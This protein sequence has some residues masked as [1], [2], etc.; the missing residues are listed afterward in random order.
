MIESKGGKIKE[1]VMGDMDNKKRQQQIGMICAVSCAVIWGIL[2]VYWKS[3]ESINSFMIM[4]YRLLLAFIVVLVVCL[5][6]YKPEGILKPLKN[7]KVIPMFF[8]AGFIIS[9]NWST[10]IWA[11]NAGHIIQTSIGYYIEPLF[12]AILGLIIFHEKLNKYKTIAI[13]LAAIGVCIMI[14]SYG[15][16]PTIAL[17]L[18]VSFA[19]YAALKKKLQAPALLALLYETG[20]MLPIVIPC[21]IFMEVTGRGV[22]GT[23]DVNQ[24]ILLSFSGILTAI[25]LSLFGLAANRVSI[26]TLGLTE[27]LS[28][29]LNL[30]IGIFIYSEPF[31]MIQL[32]GFIVIWIGLAVFTIGEVKG[33]SSGGEGVERL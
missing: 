20:L 12:V 8:F 32:A 5:I 11:V 26:I 28:P 30:A 6:K 1:S 25:P 29:S 23:A 21:I 3:L 27:Y 24:I 19:V 13:I 7:K 17:V 15:Q 33:F 18:A 9:V 4:F 31:D 14:V 2:P 10:Y 22:I 16:P